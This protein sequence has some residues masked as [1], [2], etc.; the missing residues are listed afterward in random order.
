MGSSQSSSSS[1]STSSDANNNNNNNDAAGAAKKKSLY[2]RAQEKKRGPG[3]SGLSDE[4]LQKYTG[5]TRAEFDAWKETTPGVGKN[6]LAGKLAVGPASGLG[7]AATAGGLG[8]W[9]PDA[10]PNDK[11]RGMKFPPQP[12]PQKKSTVDEE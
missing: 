5:K 7:G 8:G 6:Q 10:E 4:D 3:T 1:S 9:G 2:Q 12:L 11:D